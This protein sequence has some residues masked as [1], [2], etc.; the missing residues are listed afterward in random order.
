MTIF[1]YLLFT[2]TTTLATVSF[3]AIVLTIVALIRYRR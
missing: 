3:F 1:L 2:L